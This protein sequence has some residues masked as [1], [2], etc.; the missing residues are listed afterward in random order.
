MRSKYRIIILLSPVLCWLIC[1]FLLPLS[2]VFIY[3]FLERDAHG[4]IQWTFTIENYIRSIDGLYLQVLW[5]SITTGFVCTIFCLLIG[6]PFAYSLAVIR[7][8][9]RDILL[10]LI[11]IPF[12]INFLIRTYAWI[13]ILRK[14]GILNSLITSLSLGIQPFELLNTPIAVQIGLIYTYLPFMI[15][16]LYASLEQID[17]SLIDAAK[18]LGATPRNAF[19]QVTFP[20][21]LPGILA[22]SMLVFIPTVGAFLTPDLLGG[23][24]VSYIGNVIERQFKSALDYPFG[25]ALSILLM[26]FVLLGIIIYFRTLRESNNLDY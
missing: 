26:C 9:Y 23:G 1:F 8:K 5:R 21:S 7:P 10:L 15:L 16:P 25:S 14:E 22:G 24:K 3:S 12:W 6:Y 2:Y 4:G 19:W 18:D 13:L 20:L 17:F 11:V